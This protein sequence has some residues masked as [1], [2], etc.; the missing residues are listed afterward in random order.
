LDV[1]A[2]EGELSWRFSRSSGPGGQSVNTTDSRASASFDLAGS[3]ALGPVQRDRALRRLHTRLVDGVLTVTASDHRSQLAN[4][5]AA[6]ARLVALLEEAIAPPP[7]RR[8]P[9]RPSRAAAERRLTDKKRRGDV[10][11]LRQPP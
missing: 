5:R 9:T 11:R 4:R 8:K 10:K 6:L 2:L 7:K 1:N 3:A